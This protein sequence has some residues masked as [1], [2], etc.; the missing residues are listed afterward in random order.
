VKPLEVTGRKNL[1]CAW[2]QHEAVVG[3]YALLWANW[4]EVR[5][6]QI[7]SPDV[8]DLRG[9]VMVYVEEADFTAEW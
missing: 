9:F 7:E 8:S 2:N 3:V 4:D 1:A 5:R 6:A